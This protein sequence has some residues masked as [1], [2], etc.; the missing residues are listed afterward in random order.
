MPLIPDG[1]EQL[2]I[3]LIM[4]IG[5][6]LCL[7]LQRLPRAGIVRLLLRAFP[8][9]S[10]S[11]HPRAG[12]SAAR[13]TANNGT[14]SASMLSQSPP[15]EF[16]NEVEAF[17]LRPMAKIERR[18]GMAFK[19]KSM[20]AF[21]SASTRSTSGR[22]WRSNRISGRRLDFQPSPRLGV[23]GCP[24]LAGLINSAPLPP[25]PRGQCRSG[26]AGHRAPGRRPRHTDPQGSGR[27]H[28]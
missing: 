15:P 22:M 6:H 10:Q 11:R 4:F 16:S 14:V 5:V 1:T 23:A 7:Q 9:I 25:R 13:V 19:R 12:M 8:A 26:A 20:R 3:S 2:L 18:H 21:T 24:V 17:I 27:G 28:R